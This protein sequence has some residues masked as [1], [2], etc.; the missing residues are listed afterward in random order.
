[1][2]FYAVR[3]PVGVSLVDTCYIGFSQRFT[4]ELAPWLARFRPSIASRA[5]ADSPRLL[6][7]KKSNN[8]TSNNI[9]LTSFVPGPLSY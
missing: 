6:E 5:A 7:K 3:V 2:G 4:P 9:D 8:F 1:M